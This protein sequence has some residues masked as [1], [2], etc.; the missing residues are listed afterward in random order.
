MNKELFER[1]S[2]KII[3][4]VF[5]DEAFKQRLIA[6]PKGVF[7]EYDIDFPEDTEIRILENTDKVF[8]F[9]LP[10]RAPEPIAHM[11]WFSEAFADLWKLTF[12]DGNHEKSWAEIREED[13]KIFHKVG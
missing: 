1:Q 10:V 6:D 9:V 8:H 4:R 5:A 11:D 13:R 12:G 3:D 2:K 7:R